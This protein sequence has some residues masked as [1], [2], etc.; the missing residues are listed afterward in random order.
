MTGLDPYAL[1]AAE[2]HRIADSIATLAGSGLPQP[3]VS[4]TILP[5]GHDDADSRTIVARIDRVAAALQVGPATTRRLSG[6]GFYHGNSYASRWRGPVS[7]AVFDEVPDPAA[8][9]RDAEVER[10]RAELAAL[11]DAGTA[12]ASAPIPRQELPLITVTDEA[13]ALDFGRAGVNA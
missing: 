5:G 11:H 9:E 8:L 13:S 10:L 6:G 7:V 2:L 1:V 3:S 12:R 4:I